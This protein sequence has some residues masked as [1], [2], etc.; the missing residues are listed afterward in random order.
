M[1]KALQQALAFFSEQR[2][3]ENLRRDEKAKQVLLSRPCSIC[4]LFGD[5]T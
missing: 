4:I 1:L 5:Y 3:D 2:D